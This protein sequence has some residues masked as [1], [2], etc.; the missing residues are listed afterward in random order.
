M[1]MRSF[2]RFSFIRSLCGNGRRGCLRGLV[3]GGCSVKVDVRVA[4]GKSRAII[5]VTAIIIILFIIASP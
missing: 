1:I 3:I 5:I 2:G 4:P